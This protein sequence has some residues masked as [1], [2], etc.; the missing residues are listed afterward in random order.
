MYCSLEVLTCKSQV[1][2]KVSRYMCTSQLQELTVFGFRAFLAIIRII[3]HRVKVLLIQ[4]VRA[5]VRP[6]KMK[7]DWGQ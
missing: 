7:E 2:C 1:V 6:G 5:V 4:L 3:H